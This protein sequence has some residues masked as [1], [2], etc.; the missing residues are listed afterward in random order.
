M[1]LGLHQIT[2]VYKQCFEICTSPPFL[3]VQ[4]KE[5]NLRNWYVV[6][7]KIKGMDCKL[8]F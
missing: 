8:R 2:F 4:M 5:T 6:S 7:Q 3:S 1:L